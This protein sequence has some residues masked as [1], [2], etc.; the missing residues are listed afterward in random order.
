MA[1]NLPQDFTTWSIDQVG[2]W[3]KNINLERYVSVFKLLEVDGQCLKV[4][5]PSD[6]E[7][8]EFA[9]LPVHRRKIMEQ[10]NLLKTGVNLEN[11]TNNNLIPNSLTSNPFPIN[12]KKETKKLILTEEKKEVL[13]KENRD[14]LSTLELVII[15]DTQSAEKI[16][17]LNQVGGT[18]GRNGSFW[19]IEENYISTIHALI[20]YIDNS[21]YIKDMG[22]SYGT[23]VIVRNEIRVMQ[24]DI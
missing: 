11:K 15:S 1:S 6:L 18:I 13:H 20:E 12:V 19:K 21:Y 22:S 7:S 17:K 3:L 5:I 9:I 8:N 24:G 10:I 14:Q 16:K 4:I 23:Y 2:I